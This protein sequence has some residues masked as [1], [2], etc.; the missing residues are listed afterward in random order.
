MVKIIFILI[1]KL[2]CLIIRQCKCGRNKFVK[3][4]C[5]VFIKLGKNLNYFFLRKKLTR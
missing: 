2:L 5:V 3:T 4:Q 1:Q